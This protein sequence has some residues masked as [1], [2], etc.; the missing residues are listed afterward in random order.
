MEVPITFSKTRAR[1]GDQPAHGAGGRR[2]RAARAAFFRRR[3][4]FARSASARSRRSLRRR[5]KSEAIDVNASGAPASRIAAL[6]RAALQGPRYGAALQL[7]LPLR[8]VAAAAHPA[9]DVEAQQEQRDH[10]EQA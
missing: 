2:M 9:F 7:A 6:T 5:R 3:P 1:G 10:F 8:G 4:A